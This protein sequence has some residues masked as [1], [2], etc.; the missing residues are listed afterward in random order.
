MATPNRVSAGTSRAATRTSRRSPGHRRRTAA[1]RLV[2]RTSALT[3]IQR[4]VAAHGGTSITMAQLR[5]D[6]L[7][8]IVRETQSTGLT[9]GNT[10]AFYIQQLAQDGIV[11]MFRRGH[12]ALTQ[13]VVER[14]DVSAAV[15]DAALE[16]DTLVFED[17]ETDTA[18]VMVRR[19]KG[20]ARLRIRTLARYGGQCAVCD[21]RL[22]RLLVC[23]HV[24]RWADDHTLRGRLDNAMCLCTLHDS[25]FE[26]G[27]W[28]MNSQL[29]IVR[30]TRPLSG[31]MRAILPA[32]MTFRPPSDRPPHP[33]FLA[34]HRARVGLTS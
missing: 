4:C 6:E 12:Y 22:A 29:K 27:F 5:D 15:L 23:S 32:T 20:Q 11:T 17:V 30:S 1:P 24:V 25:A 8:Q 7:A 10:L 28:S 21:E 13:V 14:A 3:A 9:P 19:R 26:H 34:R 2:W 33:E 18:P 16:T 31:T